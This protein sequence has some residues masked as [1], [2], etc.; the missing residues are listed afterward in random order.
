MEDGDV[1]DDLHD[2]GEDGLGGAEDDVPRGYHRHE[3]ASG[4][5]KIGWFLFFVSVVSFFSLVYVLCRVCVCVRACVRAC[6]CVCVCVRLCVCVVLTC[7][8]GYCCTS[9][10]LWCTYVCDVMLLSLCAVYCDVC[11]LCMCTL[12]SC[13]YSCVVA[14]SC[15]CC[16]VVRLIKQ[17]SRILYILVHGGNSNHSASPSRIIFLLFD[18]QLQ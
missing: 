14:Y 2:G 9:W 11:V 10:V 8:V 3:L 1:E 16:G 18:L 13:V 15:A 12:C 17:G 6:V 7:A 5:R 4:G